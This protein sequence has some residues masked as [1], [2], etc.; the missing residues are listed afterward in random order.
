M[1]SVRSPQPA[2]A[3]G[4]I[5]LPSCGALAAAAPHPLSALLWPPDSAVF[6]PDVLFPI[7]M[8]SPESIA[9]TYPASLTCML[10]FPEL[11]FGSSA[12][13]SGMNALV[14]P[15]GARRCSQHPGVINADAH[16]CV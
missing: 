8:A 10:L 13:Q 7:S 9:Q 1:G 11:Q 6:V 12:A 16:R 5:Q 2:A 14:E 15:P 3:F 4:L